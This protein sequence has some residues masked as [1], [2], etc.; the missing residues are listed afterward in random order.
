[1]IARK[2]N[3]PVGIGILLLFLNSVAPALFGQGEDTIVALD[4]EKWIEKMNDKLAIDLSA[5]ND[6]HRFELRTDDLRLVLYPNTPTNLKLKLNYRFLSVG[7]KYAPTF[8]PGNDDTEQ[9][10]TTKNFGLQT[11]LIFDH[12]FLDLA[13]NSVNGF[14]L[15]NSD[16]LI[17]ELEEGEY[18]LFPDLKYRGFRISSG[19]SQNTNFS[20]RSLTTQTER[21]LKSAGSFMPMINFRYYIIDDQSDG[22]TTQ[23]SNNT[24]VDIGPG[25]AYTFVMNEN[26]Y[27]SLGG[28]ANMGYLR[29]KLTTRF[30]DGDLVTNSDN[31]VLRLDGRTGIGY[32]GDRFYTGLYATLSETRYRQESTTAINFDTRLLYHL[33]FGVRIKA[34]RFIEK[35]VKS[36]EKKLQ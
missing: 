13:Y 5:N 8:I 4:S 22:N 17:S 12:W 10:G 33:F 6:F 32:N 3:Y 23:K 24:E 21:Q 16:E 18:L 29:T 20:L 30:P 35:P 1:M 14:Y 2:Q 36:V 28:S 19:Y 34:P 25:Y 26:F 27:F 9:R 31:L 7:I 11:E 15:R